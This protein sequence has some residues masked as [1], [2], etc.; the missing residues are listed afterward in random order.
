VREE[1]KIQRQGK[2]HVLYPG[3]LNEVHE[4]FEGFTIQTTLLEAGEQPIVQAHFTGWR[5]GTDI[6]EAEIRT[7]GIGTAGRGTDRTGPAKDAP[8]EMAETRAKARA[9]RDAVN[10]GETA[11]EE[12]PSEAED[13]P[14]PAPNTTSNA[15]K[16]AS[17]PRRSHVQSQTP[18]DG[19]Q[20]LGGEYDDEPNS[21]SGSTL[22]RLNYQIATYSDMKGLDVNSQVGSLCGHLE[23]RGLTELSEYQGHQWIARYEKNIDKAEAAQAKLEEGA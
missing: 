7:S 17:R 3:L 11:F 18:S 4:R 12:L 16:T 6:A 19:A 14:Q 2:T 13:T 8:I 22:G 10:I 1:Y 15:S 5:K 9:F 23:V 20:P 21:I